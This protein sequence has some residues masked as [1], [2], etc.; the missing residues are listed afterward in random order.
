MELLQNIEFL[1]TYYF[2]LVLLIPIVWYL[3]YKKQRSGLNFIF[4]ED[5]KKVFW[6]NSILFYIKISLFLLLLCNFIILLA[7]PQFVN[8]KK[9]ITKNGI[10]IVL[11]FDVSGSMEASDLQP[12]RMEAA[13][14]VLDNFIWNLKTDRLG[15][16]IF[17][18]KP[19]TS[20]PLTFDYN[21]L[22]ENIQR[23]STSSINQQR[24]WLNGTAI[25]DAILMSKTLFKAPKWVSKEEYEKRQKV[26]ILLTDG[27]ANV[28]VDP[29]LTS[30]SA[31]K[32]NIKIYTIGI[33]SEKW[34]SIKINIG[35]WFTQEQQIPPLNDTALK[36][37]AQNTSWEFFR[38]TDNNSFTKIFDTLQKLEKN[39]I[40]IHITKL[41]TEY[42]TYF[43]II[44]V[45][46]LFIFSVLIFKDIDYASNKF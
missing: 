6:W 10:D 18:W 38:A 39:D 26:I 43:I 12:N 16:V 8:S 45:L 37:I 13:K 4:I 19:F 5:I 9:D 35:W 15:L 42:Y 34:G 40:K 3:F 44:L 23:L 33:G 46:N 29:V 24:N 21:I 36:E 17:A 30:L 28:W 2:W 14:K 32:E 25:W 11:A 31:K 22:K 27:D 20:I 41:Y 1:D 7:N